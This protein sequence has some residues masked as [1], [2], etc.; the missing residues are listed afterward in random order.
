MYLIPEMK[1]PS[2]FTPEPSAMHKTPMNFM[3]FLSKVVSD[4][5][6]ID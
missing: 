5:H 4:V 3:Q 2:Y 1:G 6:F